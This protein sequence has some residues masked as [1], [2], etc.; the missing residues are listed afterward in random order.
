MITIAIL[1]KISGFADKWQW[2]KTVFFVCDRFQSKTR[3][4]SSLCDIQC[5]QSPHNFA[6]SECVTASV[7]QLRQQKTTLSFDQGCSGA[8]TRRDG[9]PQFF[10][11]GGRVPHSPHFF[12]HMNIIVSDTRSMLLVSHVSSLLFIKLHGPPL[13]SWK[14][15]TYAKT[16]LR[17]HRSATDTQTNTSSC[18]AEQDQRS[19]VEIFLTCMSVR[20][21]RPKLF[22]NLCLSLVS[23]VPPLLF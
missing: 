11:Q 5:M 9:V 10:R 14:P 2:R 4:H 8:G 3:H 20:V 19:A 12:R 22:K 21:C 16:W 23:G 1:V 15:T 6:E 7:G 13:N 17:K 18:I